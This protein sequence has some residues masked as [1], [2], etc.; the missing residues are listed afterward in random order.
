M[1]EGIILIGDLDDIGVETG[2]SYGV[3]LG[4]DNGIGLSILM[5]DSEIKDDDLDVSVTKIGLSY[6]LK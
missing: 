1:L 6:N 5:F 3:G 2:F 4:F